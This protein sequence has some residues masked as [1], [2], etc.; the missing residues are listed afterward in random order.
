MSIESEVK[1]LKLDNVTVNNGYTSINNNPDSLVEGLLDGLGWLLGGLLGALGELIDGLLP[2]L[3]LSLDKIVKDLLSVKIASEDV[4][5]TGAFAGR[6]TGNVTVSNCV[7]TNSSVS[8]NKSMLGGFVGY[9]EGTE[10]YD[11]LSKLLG[12]VT[13]LLTAL[14]NILPGIGLGDLI[15]VLLK[16]DIG[17]GALIPTRCV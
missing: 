1:N 2:G 10:E 15:T 8:S 14:L 9:T 4:F 12:G 5:A 13:G 17:L 11:G 6:I 3:N 7:V 16:N